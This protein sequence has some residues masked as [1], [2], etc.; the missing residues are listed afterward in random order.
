MNRTARTTAIRTAVATTVAGVSLLAAAGA[1]SA[2]QV[3]VLVAE[4]GSHQV[5]VSPDEPYDV[6]DELL[7]TY[8]GFVPLDGMC[9]FDGTRLVLSDMRETFFIQEHERG[10]QAGAFTGTGTILDET[11]VLDQLD[12]EGNV[13]RTFTGTGDEYARFRGTGAAGQVADQS[14]NLRVTFRGDSED[15]VRVDFGIRMR[16]TVDH[17]G[18]P[19]FAAEVDHCRTR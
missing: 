1:A 5:W 13:V 14:V 15:G 16:M 18:V 17:D 10:A 6:P 8:W 3:P 11:F 9:G 2:E 4:H 7:N 19:S 12:A